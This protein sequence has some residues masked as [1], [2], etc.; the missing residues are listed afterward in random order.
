LQLEEYLERS[1]DSSMVEALEP[2]VNCLLTYFE[3]FENQ[4]GLLE[5][6]ESWVFIEWSKANEFV[7]DVNFPSNMLYAAALEAA[8]RM[9]E[10]QSLEQKADHLREVIRKQS[11][12]GQFFVDNAV[13]EDH[14][15]EATRN[16]TE[17]AQYFA[18]FFDIASPETHPTLFRILRD[19]FGPD[20]VETGVYA[21]VHPANAFV[22][23]VIR[24]ELLSRWGLTQQILDESVAYFLYMAQQTGTLWENITTVA[25]CNHGFAS[26]VVH[27]LYRDV[28]GLYRVDPASRIVKVRF[29]RLDLDWCEGRIPLV[30]GTVSLRWKKESGKLFFRLDLPAGYQAQIDNLSGLELVPE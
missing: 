8:G 28:L 9:Y 5:G 23:N 18:F 19:Q 11:F 20:R 24:M 12:D 16:R 26:H 10:N 6:L 29:P 7:Q 3:A 27:I 22:G 4:D 2:R 15:L 14:G 21:E 1:G 13:R 25:S 17:V 30:D